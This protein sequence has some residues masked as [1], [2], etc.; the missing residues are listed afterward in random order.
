MPFLL[1]VV[2]RHDHD[3]WEVIPGRMAIA[4][5]L[6]RS[7]GP[8]SAATDAIAAQIGERRLYDAHVATSG[9]A[10]TYAPV[11]GKPALLLGA[12]DIAMVGYVAEEFFI[13][14]PAL[15]SWPAGDLA[16]AER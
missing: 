16:T 12:F 6:T 4:T 1:V 3:A 7:S 15:S 14:G 8:R 13:S 11:P 5:H 2:I 9:D 10:A